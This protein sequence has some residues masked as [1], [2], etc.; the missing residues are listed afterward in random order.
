MADWIDESQE[1]QL[2]MLEAQ[3]AQATKA[4][5]KASAHFCED[6]ETAIS[7]QR[8]KIIPGVQRC[9]ECQEI[10]EIKLRNYRSI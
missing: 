1:H 2:R 4:T 7:E 5:R 6:C 8:R 3:I 9:T 10:N